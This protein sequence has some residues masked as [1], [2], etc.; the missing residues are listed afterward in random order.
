MLSKSGY[1]GDMAEISGGVTD[2]CHNMAMTMYVCH[3]G[4][5]WT[6]FASWDA[7]GERRWRKRMRERG[8]WEKWVIFPLKQNPNK[9]TRQIILNKQ[10]RII[11]EIKRKKTHQKIVNGVRP[12]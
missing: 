6:L 10:S 3:G 9:A 1:C 12:I 7:S 8:C 11:K 4:P 5:W 2:Y